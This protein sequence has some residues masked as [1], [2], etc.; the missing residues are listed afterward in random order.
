MTAQTGKAKTYEC[1]GLWCIK[2][3][4]VNKEKVSEGATIRQKIENCCQT[5][6]IGY[7]STLLVPSASSYPVLITY[8]LFKDKDELKKQVSIERSSREVS[9]IMNDADN[10]MYD[11]KFSRGIY[12]NDKGR[13]PTSANFYLVIRISCEKNEEKPW[14]QKCQQ[15]WDRFVNN[16]IEPGVIQKASEDFRTYNNP[17]DII[18]SISCQTTDDLKQGRMIIEEEKNFL[19]SEQVQFGEYTHKPK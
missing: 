2:F 7:Q 12:I 16:G 10:Q 11:H 3:D 1:Q 17:S 5:V 15:I 13:F 6:G 8:D 14:L 18:W 4:T 9:N 19:Q